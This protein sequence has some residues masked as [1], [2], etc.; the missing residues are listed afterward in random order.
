SYASFPG[1]RV[2]GRIPPQF[3]RHESC[4]R[5]ADEHLASSGLG[6][7]PIGEHGVT[8]LGPADHFHG[9][10]FAARRRRPLIRYVVARTSTK[11]SSEASIPSTRGIGSKMIFRCSASL[12]ATAPVI[13]TVPKSTTAREP[14]QWALESFTGSPSAAIWTEI[15]IFTGPLA[16]L[17]LSSSNRK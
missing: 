5:N 6:L 11:G 1:F 17:R 12:L 13:S 7:G 9:F 16:S 2:R 8:G 4:R 3:G 15:R 10:T 14:G